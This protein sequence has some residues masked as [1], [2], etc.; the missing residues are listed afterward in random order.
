MKRNF[1]LPDNISDEVI[2]KSEEMSDADMEKILFSLY[3]TEYFTAILKYLL[4]RALV[5]QSSINTVDPFK[6]PTKMARYQGV[7]NGLMDLPGGVVAV[8]EN[9]KAKK[10]NKQRDL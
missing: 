6:E 8:R 5:A 1:Y 7:I 4:E 9:N 3:E 2:Q 10:S